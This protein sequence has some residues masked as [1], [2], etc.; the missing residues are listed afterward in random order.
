MRQGNSPHN[1]VQEQRI[2][3]LPRS[4][5]SNGVTL[6]EKMMTVDSNSNNSNSGSVEAYHEVR[7]EL[8]NMGHN[9]VSFIFIIVY[10]IIFPPFIIISNNKV[11]S[12]K[13]LIHFY[14]LDDLFFVDICF[15]ES[16]RICIGFITR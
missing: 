13:K 16:T 1:F 5:S 3:E 8:R 14:P 12:I 11:Q 6:R 9:L 15:D 4:S 7:L 10:C 2:D